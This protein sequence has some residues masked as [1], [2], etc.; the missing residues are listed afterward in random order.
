[1]TASTSWPVLAQ[2][3]EALLAA[4]SGVAPGDWDR[5]TPCSE[6][7]AAQVLQHAAGDQLGYAA[8]LGEGTG[9]DEDPFAPSGKLGGEPVAVA[10]AAVRTA[11][12][13]W[14]RVPEDAVDVT[15]PLPPNKMPAALGAHVCA[16]DAAVHA[17]DI[18]VATGQSSPL[19]AELAAELLDAARQ[20]VE[21]LRAFAFA[22]VVPAAPDDDAIA[23][24]LKY[25]GRNPD[26]TA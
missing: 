10:E 3:H 5:H 18:A 19:T 17:W 11:A 8:F 14:S 15:V 20:F 24:L 25:L 26:W 16:L 9:P 23:E 7:N 13:A 4:V 1:M 12:T 6:W 22:P 21:P 2:A